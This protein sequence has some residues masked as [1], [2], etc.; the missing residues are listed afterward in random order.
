MIVHRI[1]VVVDEVI[2]VD[3][4]DVTVHVVVDAVARDLTGVDPHVRSQ[5]GMRVI[6]AGV[7]DGHDNVGRSGRDVPRLGRIN[8]SIDHAAELAGVVHAPQIAEERIVGNRLH[9]VYD[10]V[11]FDVDDVLQRRGQH[12]DQAEVAQRCA[13]Q[14]ER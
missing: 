2:A 14:S 1:A 8:V 12:V 4:V 13:E 11:R 3:V 6:H 5:V 10:E 9:R 7:D